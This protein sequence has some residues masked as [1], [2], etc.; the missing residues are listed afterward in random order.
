MIPLLGLEIYV[1]EFWVITWPTCRTVS[2]TGSILSSPFTSRFKVTS[3]L[4]FFHAPHPICQV[5]LMPD[6][7]LSPVHNLPREFPAEILLILL[8]L[9]LLIAFSLSALRDV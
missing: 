3:S 6:V 2:L 9:H 7:P 4:D 1:I 8:Y 5:V